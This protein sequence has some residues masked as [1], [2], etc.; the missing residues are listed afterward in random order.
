MNKE[1]KMQMNGQNLIDEG[2]SIPLRIERQQKHD[3]IAV[4]NN[5]NIGKL[6]MEKMG[7]NTKT[8][9]SNPSINTLASSPLEICKTHPNKIMAKID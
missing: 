3:K 1:I 8:E 7:M 9:K 6:L 2:S 5:R 4:E